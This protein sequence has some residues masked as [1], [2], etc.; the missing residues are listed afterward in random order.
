LGAFINKPYGKIS[1]KKVCLQK[2]NQRNINS[3][4]MDMMVTYRM[5]KFLF[6]VF[7][8]EHRDTVDLFLETSDP[9]LG[10]RQLVVYEDEPEMAGFLNVEDCDVAFL[11]AKD[12]VFD[13]YVVIPLTAEPVILERGLVNAG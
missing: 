4:E 10:W 1:N 5:K 6:V 8:F 13:Y 2:N 7:G 12:T 9:D 3:V 11:E